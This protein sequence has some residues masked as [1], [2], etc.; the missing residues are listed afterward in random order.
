MTN[1][2]GEPETSTPRTPDTCGTC[3]GENL[4]RL[5]MVL[6]DGTDVTFISCQACEAREWLSAEPDQS[7]CTVPIESVLERSARHR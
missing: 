2:P 7:W 6:A 3:G 4:T 1:G 5:P